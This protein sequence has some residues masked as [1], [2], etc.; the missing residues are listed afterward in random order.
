MRPRGIRGDAIEPRTKTQLANDLWQRTPGNDEGVL[1]K[2]A[3]QFIVAD[4]PRQIRTDA[5]VVRLKERSER[6]MIALPRPLDKRLVWRFTSQPLNRL[7]RDVFALIRRLVD[8]APS[9]IA[10]I[11]ICAPRPYNARATA[12]L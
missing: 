4:E 8:H 3:P 10:I 11:C 5:R 9:P 12:N 6:L 7:Q 2:V 1:C